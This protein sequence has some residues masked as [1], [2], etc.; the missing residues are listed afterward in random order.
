M[1]ICVSMSPEYK[2]WQRELNCDRCNF[3]FASLR[4]KLQSRYCIDQVLMTIHSALRLEHRKFPSNQIAPYHSCCEVWGKMKFKIFRT[5]KKWDVE[6][7]EFSYLLS[8]TFI[9]FCQGGGWR[10]T[11]M[12]TGTC[13]HQPWSC[14]WNGKNAT[15]TAT[16]V[17]RKI[18][19]NC[20]EE[21]FELS[22]TLPSWKVCTQVWSTDV[23]SWKI[24]FDPIQKFV[25]IKCSWVRLWADNHR[26]IM[27]RFLRQ[28]YELKEIYIE[29]FEITNN[30]LFKY[31]YFHLRC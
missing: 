26:G 19:E 24:S 29:I 1:C 10:K 5:D 22:R 23:V 21:I 20:T 27:Q 16:A 6:F 7:E 11:D 13:A 30:L 28:S 9:F 8:R 12:H 4:V 15:Q 14:M 31:M 17:N 18:L 25:K 3:I 2:S